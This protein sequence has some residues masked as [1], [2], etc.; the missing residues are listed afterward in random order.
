MTD[1]FANLTDAN[2]RLAVARKRY[3]EAIQDVRNE[4]ITVDK[5]RQNLS[6]EERFSRNDIVKHCTAYSREKVYETLGAFDIFST[7]QKALREADNVHLCGSTGGRV[8]LGFEPS[9]ED[10]TDPTGEYIARYNQAGGIK[11]VLRE[12]GLQLTT[13]SRSNY[14]TDPVEALAQGEE[15]QI[16]K[17][18]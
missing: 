15:V 6:E 17:K 12:V 11:I 8:L 13:L 3:Q 4:I 9:F 18:S 10:D 1:H 5:T 7:A 16:V 14:E 2:E